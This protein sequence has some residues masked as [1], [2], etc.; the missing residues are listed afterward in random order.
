MCMNLQKSIV[1]LMAKQ[2]IQQYIDQVC[3]NQSYLHVKFDLILTLSNL[4][5]L[6]PNIPYSENFDGGKV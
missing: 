6:S 5:N 3:K 4:I 1:S 2:S